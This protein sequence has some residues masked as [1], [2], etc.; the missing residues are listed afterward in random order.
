MFHTTVASITSGLTRIV[1][2][3][4]EHVANQTALARQHSES[5]SELASKRDAADIEAINASNI[6]DKIAA[7]IS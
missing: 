6:R 7:L 4:E 3:L 5:I 1:K 2:R